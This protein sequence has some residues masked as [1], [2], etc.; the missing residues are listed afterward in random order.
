MTL[1]EIS[2]QIQNAPYF[3]LVLDKTYDMVSQEATM[4][5]YFHD[6]V[7]QERSTGF[8]NVSAD[9]SDGLFSHI[10]TVLPNFGLESK[11]MMEH[12]F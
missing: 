12:P 6:G 1:D 7:V 2:R 3:T 9:N 10:Q 4:L 5:R 8:T 11:H